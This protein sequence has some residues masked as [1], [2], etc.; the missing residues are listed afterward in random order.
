MNLKHSIWMKLLIFISCSIPPA[1]LNATEGDVSD[2]SFSVGVTIATTYNIHNINQSIYNDEYFNSRINTGSG[3]GYS[4]AIVFD[5]PVFMRKDRESSFKFGV[6]YEFQN[7]DYSESGPKVSALDEE[8]NLRPTSTKYES[9]I[10]FRSYFFNIAYQIYF[11]ESPNFGLFAGV[12]LNYIQYNNIIQSVITDDP[13]RRFERVANWQDRGW[14]YFNNDRGI[15]LYDGGFDNMREFIASIDIGIYHSL[16]FADSELKFY[17]AIGSDLTALIKDS[18]WRR[19]F[20]RPGI[21][22]SFKI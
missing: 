7:P 8:N 1:L 9:E 14:D 13:S 4:G 21:E 10:N 19:F 11:P 6:G 22:Y 2:Y 3:F 15:V 12:T 17:I 18:D 16:R 20:L 5:I